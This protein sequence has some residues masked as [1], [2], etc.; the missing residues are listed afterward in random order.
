MKYLI[1]FALFLI[2]QRQLAQVKIDTIGT[3]YSLTFEEGELYFTTIN[4]EGDTVYMKTEPIKSARQIDGRIP[5]F[6]GHRL[7][8]NS[9]DYIFFQRKICSLDLRPICEEELDGVIGQIGENYVV[10]KNDT[11][12]ILETD[13]QLKYFGK[14]S[15]SNKIRVVHD[16]AFMIENLETKR[17]QFFDAY[18]NKKGSMKGIDGSF[19]HVTNEYLVCF[20]V[21][22]PSADSY[23]SYS[24]QFYNFK[25]DLVAEGRIIEENK[26]ALLIENYE[27]INEFY[28]KGQ[29]M[30]VPQDIAEISLLKYNL[31]KV[32]LRN[33][34]VGIFTNSLT[35]KII[36]P[37]FEEIFIRD[38]K[39]SLKEF[40]QSKYNMEAQDFFYALDKNHQ[41]HIFDYSGEEIDLPFSIKGTPN[42]I[43]PANSFH[44]NNDLLFY[45]V[46]E[47]LEKF[48]IFD[49]DWNYIATETSNNKD[50][51]YLSPSWSSIPIKILK[52][53]P[54]QLKE[55][56]YYRVRGKNPT[57]NNIIGTDLALVF[58]ENLGKVKKINKNHFIISHNWEYDDE[59]KYIIKI[60]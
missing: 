32:K 18:G 15:R 56:E 53:F 57:F 21:D 60:E 54:N 23:N 43:Q 14:T 26:E 4:P 20:M 1:F 49:K 39:V 25:G 16:R 17:L 41:V 3:D 7:I 52:Y 37:I 12:F 46:D 34:K 47:S 40:D 24:H 59:E 48:H 38:V 19:Y 27:G 10:S 50:K 28:Y 9:Y 51:Y 44:L 35:K 42:M 29:Q 2:A 8:K 30:D 13:C 5:Q 55:G 6:R 36:A 22:R 33:G 45:K 31:L 58:K 11:C